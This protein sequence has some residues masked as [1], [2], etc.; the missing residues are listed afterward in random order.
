M[1][2]RV[3]PWAEDKTRTA[4]YF[5]DPKFARIYP[6]QRYHY[7]SHLIPAEYQE[8]HLQNT[9]WFE[10]APGEKPEQLRYPD[11]ELI[12]EIAPDV[13]KCVQ[14]ARVFEALDDL[15]CPKDPAQ[16]R[17]QCHGDYRHTRPI[18]LSRGFTEEELF[19][20]FHVL[21]AKGGFCDC[22]I[23]FNAAEG[24]RL[25]AEYW[26]ARAEGRAAPDPHQGRG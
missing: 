21:M 13:M 1:T 5:V 9:V 3:E 8:R 23:L 24:S 18:L 2:I 17:A 16:P 20:V 10:L 26:Q 25:A 7:L 6:L 15:F 4:I 22:E 12:A 19:D 14:A 11:E